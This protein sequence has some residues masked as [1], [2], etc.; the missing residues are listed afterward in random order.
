MNC[1]IERNKLPSGIDTTDCGDT[2]IS[3]GAIRIKQEVSDEVLGFT[4]SS[5][6]SQSFD[7][8]ETGRGLL[9]CSREA[10]NPS[11]IPSQDCSNGR[12]MPDTDVAAGEGNGLD[13]DGFLMP[14]V[15]SLMD[16]N[17]AST[18]SCHSAGASTNSMGDERNGEFRC[19]LCNYSGRSQHCLNK[20]FRAHSQA[21]K[22]CRYCMKAFERPSDLVRHEERHQKRNHVVLKKSSNVPISRSAEYVSNRTSKKRR[23][24]FCQQC[25][26][27]C[28]EARKLIVHTRKMHPIHFE[29]KLCH[30]KFTSEAELAE[31]KAARHPVALG[32]MDT[33]WNGVVTATKLVTCEVTNDQEI[34]ISFDEILELPFGTDGIPEV[35]NLREA[36]HIL[37]K[38]GHDREDSLVEDYVV[39]SQ[40]GA[41]NCVQQES[42]LAIPST[43]S[44]SVEE[45]SPKDIC[46]DSLGVDSYADVLDLSS[47]S[48]SYSLLKDKTELVSEKTLAEPAAFSNMTE[49]VEQA[50]MQSSA[51]DYPESEDMHTVE[52]LALPSTSKQT[53][54][55]DNDS[56]EA[57]ASSDRVDRNRLP[58]LPAL[59]ETNCV[60]ILKVLG[61]EM[62][63]PL[64]KKSTNSRC[65]P[66]KLAG[67]VPVKKLPRDRMNFVE[68][69]K[70]VCK[71][72]KVE[73]VEN[74][75]ADE[76]VLPTLVSD[77]VA[78]LSGA[79]E[80]APNDDVA[81]SEASGFP[82]AANETDV[83]HD[84]PTDVL[85]S[86]NRKCFTFICVRC[87][88]STNSKFKYQQHLKAHNGRFI[89][90]RCN[91]AC[92]KSSD[93][94]R[95]WVTH[96]VKGPNGHFACDSC[97]F[98]SPQKYAIENH[99]KQHYMLNP[100]Q[101]RHQL[102]LMSRCGICQKNVLRSRLFEHKRVVHGTFFT[103]PR[104]D[105]GEMDANG[106]SIK[107]PPKT[108]ACPQCD[109][110]FTTPSYLL[111][112]HFL[113]HQEESDSGSRAKAEEN[114]ACCRFC[115]LK[116]D[117]VDLLQEH[118]ISHIV[119]TCSDV[120][121]AERCRKRK[122]HHQVPVKTN[123]VPSVVK[124]D[125]TK[126]LKK[127]S[128]RRKLS[129][130]HCGK[131]FKM[132]YFLDQHMRVHSDERP[133]VCQ[134]CG[135]GFAIFQY[136]NIHRRFKCPNRRAE[137]PVVLTTQK[138]CSNSEINEQADHSEQLLSQQC[139]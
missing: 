105:D 23:T 116:F 81:K 129:C 117:D 44:A 15:D 30:M 107:V 8:P 56:F 65:K 133:F 31:H 46:L 6:A 3:S 63:V 134:W 49:I 138:D 61:R 38:N 19:N 135:A 47:T 16:L 87:K 118:E 130:P 127:R 112:H 131:H 94:Y 139:N 5:N 51:V 22:I 96:N 123:V 37:N 75:A 39:L 99:M 92:I 70:I 28:H 35:S 103:K 66:A 25:D 90:K 1:I 13:E 136:L 84:K 17:Y 59:T 24:W 100:A 78:G 110:R 64:A 55:S 76:P 50:Q 121:Y 57:T 73:A 126:S 128:P 45:E 43:E 85:D 106:N 95:H 62:P 113:H 53:P 83:K 29:C 93:L 27:S 88:Y 120:N 36:R 7:T 32:R 115:G 9:S 52:D 79:N 71:N 111:R 91:K 42:S 12:W 82:D 4:V 67:K 89:C 109:R 20:H 137:A 104:N 122:R 80:I 69:I 119:Q 2:E 10:E 14:L 33:Y 26:F 40:E 101:P 98:T 68:K 54:V 114:N 21:C 86:L 77:A 108:F 97:D 72:I 125:T 58:T 102:S 18:K 11:E 60:E 48:F 132:Q 34:S 74:G 41:I 124:C